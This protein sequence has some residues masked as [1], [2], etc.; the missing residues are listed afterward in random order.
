MHESLATTRH[1][2][3]SKRGNYPE[4][5]FR[6]VINSGGSP[7][8]K[9][10]EGMPGGKYQERNPRGKERMGKERN[11]VDR[12]GTER[13][14]TNQT[15]RNLLPHS[16]KYPQQSATFALLSSAIHLGEPFKDSLPLREE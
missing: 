12:E 13:E 5:T 8:G 16:T 7:A 15:V 9:Q 11:G 4:K 10:C 3:D 14:G 1:S 2:R 6:P